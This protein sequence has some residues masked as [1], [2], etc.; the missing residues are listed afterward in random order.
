MK[1]IRL[2]IYDFDVAVQEDLTSGEGQ[3]L[4]GEIKY[5]PQT[6]RIEYN[7][8]GPHGAKTAPQGASRQSMAVVLLHEVVHGIFTNAD[9]NQTERMITLVSYGLAQFLRD[10][11]PKAWED[12]LSTFD[13]VKDV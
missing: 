2:G 6:I 3:A 1:N 10:N 12:I 13:G 11:Y 9:L 4:L 5:N 7:Q 8:T